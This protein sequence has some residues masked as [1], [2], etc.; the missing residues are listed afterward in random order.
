M[1]S[2]ANDVVGIGALRQAGY[3][4]VTWD[5]RG[6]WN[7]GGTLEVDHPRGSAW[8]ARPTVAASIGHRR[9]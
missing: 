8:W 7:S 6:E 4:V 5:P 2:L 9:E 3:N 1:D